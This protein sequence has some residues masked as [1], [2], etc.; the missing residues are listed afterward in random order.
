MSNRYIMGFD[1]NLIADKM[2][3]SFNRYRSTG[4]ERFLQDAR[5]YAAVLKLDP[6]VLPNSQP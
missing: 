2:L 5:R 4:E 1:F 6:E 3:D